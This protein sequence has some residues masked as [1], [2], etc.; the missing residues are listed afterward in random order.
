MTTKCSACSSMTAYNHRTTWKQL[1]PSK[2]QSTVKHRCLHCGHHF[3]TVFIM[4]PPKQFLKLVK[5][6]KSDPKYCGVYETWGLVRN[7][8]SC[9]YDKTF[10]LVDIRD[11]NGNIVRDH[12]WFR[13]S[14]EIEALQLQPGDI[15]EFTAKKVIL[16]K[17]YKG[18][19][20]VA[21]AQSPIVKVPGLA[22]YGISKILQ[23]T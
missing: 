1:E 19:D 7:Q 17:G 13:L 8:Y 12:H 15:V 6:N 10:L 18:R 14:Y 23:E 4:V 20:P 22:M 11:A 9:G 2:W 3:E 21:R 16:V 5:A